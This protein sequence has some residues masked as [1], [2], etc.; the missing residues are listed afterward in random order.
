MG[1]PHPAPSRHTKG[2][3]QR[4]RGRHSAAANT[5]SLAACVPGSGPAYG[6]QRWSR[7]GSL[8]SGTSLKHNH[9]YVSVRPTVP[10]T[11]RQGKPRPVSLSLLSHETKEASSPWQGIGGTANTRGAQWKPAGVRGQRS[12]VAG[13]VPIRH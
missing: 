11:G 12:R 2:L 4:G 8:V 5:D 10:V 3:S 7:P 1:A 6:G 9:T 13:T